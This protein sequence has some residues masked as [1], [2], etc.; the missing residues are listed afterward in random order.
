MFFSIIIPAHNEERTI[1]MA[2]QSIKNQSFKDYEV[3][4]VCDACSDKTGD[5]AR[6]FN[7]KTLDI[8]GHSSAIARNAG[9]NIAQGEWVLFCDAD[10]WYLHEFAFEQLHEKLAEIDCDLLLF[11]LIWKGVGYG[12]IR[13]T[14]GTIYPHVANKCWRRSFIADTRFPDVIHSRGEDGNFFND[15]MAKNPRV[16]EW[17]MPLYYY[18]YL[19]PGSK[20]EAFGRSVEH[21]KK[22]WSTH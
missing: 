14:K 6:A 22:Y 20:S 4:V 17:D 10:D 1:P 9:L 15:L 5:I 2:L 18:N 8:E 3:I 21:T 16:Y 19:R 11:T 13:S 12:K 7:A